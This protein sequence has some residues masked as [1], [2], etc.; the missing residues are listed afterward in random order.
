MGASVGDWEEVSTTGSAFAA[1][2]VGRLAKP[3][4]LHNKIDLKIWQCRK[5]FIVFTHLFAKRTM[6]SNKTIGYGPSE[7]YS[8]PLCPDSELG[9]FKV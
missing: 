1:G 8:G 4:I 2:F 5:R 7:V 6:K 9:F 3:S